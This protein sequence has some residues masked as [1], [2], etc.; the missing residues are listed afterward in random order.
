MLQSSHRSIPS[1]QRDDM[2]FLPAT[3]IPLFHEWLVSE[4]T[5]N[6]RYAHHLLREK[7]DLRPAAIAALQLAIERINEDV[8]ARLRLMHI[9][10][11]DPFAEE[12]VVDPARGYP[13]FLDFNTLKSYFGEVM[14][15]LLAVTYGSHGIDTWEIP[16]FLIRFH[17]AAL[18]YLERQQQVHPNG[19]PDLAVID[20]QP[21]IP[22][23]TGDDCLAF[24]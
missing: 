23:R 4:R 11:L 5:V 10:S 24:Q 16:G 6:G 2:P 8:R 21:R 20:Q 18:Q 14:S 3:P 22:G 7:A 15:G 9:I 13:A 1:I 17:E 12:R 19:D